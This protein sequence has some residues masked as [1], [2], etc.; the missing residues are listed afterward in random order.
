MVTYRLNIEAAEKKCPL[1]RQTAGLLQ[2]YQLILHNSQ[3]IEGKKEGISW[4]VTVGG[5]MATPD[6]VLVSGINALAEDLFQAG[7]KVKKELVR[8]EVLPPHQKRYIVTLIHMDSY[9]ATLLETFLKQLKSSMA[10]KV[11]ARSLGKRAAEIIFTGEEKLAGELQK[12][13]ISQGVSCYTDVIVREDAYCKNTG[14]AA[15]DMDSTVIQMEVIDELARVKGEE[16]AVSKITEKAMQ[17]ELDFIQS[18]KL[19]MSLLTGLHEE[20]LETAFSRIYLTEGA[21]RLFT[22]LHALACKTALISG[23]FT[24]FAERLQ[25]QLGINHIFANDLDIK[26]QRLSGRLK[27]EIIDAEAKSKILMTLAAEY[28]IPGACTLAIGDG[29]NDIPMLKVAGTGIAFHAKDNVRSV[30][31]MAINFTGLDSILYLTGWH[32]DEIN[33]IINT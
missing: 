26:E 2:R 9:P 11:Q 23:G 32:D 7:Y 24:W 30:I 8:S 12:E 16:E 33:C 5:Y 14:L 28:K 25:Q 18:L 3:L 17:G 4:Q 22:V 20:A 15:F 6:T 29:A 10:T 27:G 21:S 31:D 1:I 19:R 13:F